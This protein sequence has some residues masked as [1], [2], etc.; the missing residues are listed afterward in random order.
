MG[1]S[2]SDPSKKG[3]KCPKKGKTGPLALKR[4]GFA[5]FQKSGGV[6]EVL[7]FSQASKQGHTDSYAALTMI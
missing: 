6:T 7:S 5:L 4:A 1:I 2:G 3:R